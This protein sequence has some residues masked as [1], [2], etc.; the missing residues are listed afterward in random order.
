FGP[1][2]P[3]PFG[4]HVEA[5]NLLP[6][7]VAIVSFV[8]MKYT[9]RPPATTPEAEQQQK[10]MQWMTLIFPLMFYGFPSGLNLYYL[11]STSLGIWEGKRIRQ[12][13]KEQE[14]ADKEGKVIVDA[15][16]SRRNRPTKKIEPQPE[17]KG[18]L[19]GWLARLQERAEQMRL[20][21]DKRNRKR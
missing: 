18:G 21:T 11:T 2:V 14:A 12:H 16:P 15:S 19:S 4:L 13:I 7:L 10:M 3:L 8:N 9:P 6:L 5:L 17:P 20:E 1:S